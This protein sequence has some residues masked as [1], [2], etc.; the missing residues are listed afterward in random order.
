MQRR[1]VELFTAKTRLV[2]VFDVLFVLSEAS[3]V[4]Q[5][6]SQDLTAGF[7]SSNR[8]LRGKWENL[9]PSSETSLRLAT[10][11]TPLD[12]LYLVYCIDT[13]KIFECHLE[14]RYKAK[15][16]WKE[17]SLILSKTLKLVSP[18]PAFCGDP[19]Y[20][21]LAQMVSTRLVLLHGW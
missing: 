18:S 20:R 21:S 11:C 13:F 12:Y 9:S 10:F 16:A 7:C 1:I 3:F 19:L 15:T 14:L 5:I 6:R 2:S 17:G 8:L 4:R